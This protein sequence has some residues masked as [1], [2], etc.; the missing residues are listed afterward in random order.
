LKPETASGRR[1]L[2]Y[3]GVVLCFTVLLAMKGGSSCLQ[4]APQ[5]FGVAVAVC[6]IVTHDF[7]SAWF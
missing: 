7:K 4:I 2:K 1:V 3:N 5:K 6:S